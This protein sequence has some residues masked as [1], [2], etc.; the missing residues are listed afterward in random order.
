MR[1]QQSQHHAQTVSSPYPGLDSVVEHLSIRTE[2]SSST[3]DCSTPLL[4]P[5][6]A[7]ETGTRITRHT[8]SRISHLFDRDCET[9]DTATHNTTDVPSAR[10]MGLFGLTAS[11]LAFSV[12]HF[13]QFCLAITVCGL[14]GV[15]LSRASKAG[16][17]Q[18]SRWVRVLFGASFSLPLRIRA[19]CADMPCDF[20][21]YMPSLSE[22]SRRRP[23][24]CT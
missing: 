21:R 11:Y 1:G 16:K 23:P 19:S 13:L 2:G 24:F 7:V 4:L 8:S 12:V 17:Y 22:A 10:D 18:D 9:S 14:Y 6:D 15:D 5:T 20:H 3:T